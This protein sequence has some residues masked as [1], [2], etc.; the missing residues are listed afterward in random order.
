MRVAVAWS[1]ITVLLISTVNTVVYCNKAYISA[2]QNY[3]GVVAYLE[4]I[5]AQSAH[6]F[7]NK[8]TDLAFVHK[9]NKPLPVRA[10]KI[11]AAETV[12]GY[13]IIIDTM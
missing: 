6:V 12:I 9:A 5:S 10:V 7:D 4:I 1:K 13:R 3:L 2:W 8:R 11:S